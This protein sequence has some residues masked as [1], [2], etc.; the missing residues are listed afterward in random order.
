[1][2]A[3]AVYGVFIISYEA[4]KI[5]SKIKEH[6]SRREFLS[7][8]VFLSQFAMPAILYLTTNTSHKQNYN[9]ETFGFFTAYKLIESLSSPLLFQSS[10]A[11]LIVT[12][13]F[14]SFIIYL[15]L[16]A[17][18]TSKKTRHKIIDKKLLYPFISILI[19]S[20]ITPRALLGV[21][22][23]SLRFP[24]ILF[25]L[26]IAGTKFEFPKNTLKRIG[27]LSLLLIQL[28]Y[29]TSEMKIAD[30]RAKE[31]IFAS[32]V[33]KEGSSVLFA[34]NKNNNK[35][36]TKDRNFLSYIGMFIVIEKNIFTPH[37]FTNIF[38]LTPS[39]KNKNIDTNSLF[40]IPYNILINN[41][42]DKKFYR[43]NVD[44]IIKKLETKL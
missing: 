32:N 2:L 31:M 14:I 34:R 26:L 28:L 29:V 15:I 36:T 44:N 4:E 38:Y 43:I 39:E 17:Y 22:F 10:E 8:F 21:S 11:A 25:M 35:S 16:Y 6:Q 24:P 42:S 7:R 23:V 19:I 41:Q 13:F 27:L 5:I 33:I 18:A 40:P 12:I 37:I 1:L 30:S 3:C 9:G 20:I